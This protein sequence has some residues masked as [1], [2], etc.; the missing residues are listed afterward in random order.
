M[1][2]MMADLPA[3]RVETFVKPFTNVAVDYTGA[4]NY[5]L[6][7]GRGYK[8]SK[9]YIAIFVCMSI[10]AIYIELV[11]DLT[12]EACIAA[13]RRVIARRGSIENVYS[14]NGTNFVR[15]NKD[16]FQLCDAGFLNEF[17]DELSKM[18]TTWNLSPAGAPHFNGLAEA[19][20]KS[21]KTFLKK[22]MGNLT[23]TFEELSTLLCQIEASSALSVV[24]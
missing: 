11:S 16:L 19:A 13:F 1:N 5:K 21:V 15:A 3:A 2:Q 6:A 18:G 10:K 22:S 17:S 12:A 9:A 23:L 24:I 14:D 20:V 8:T 7:K 4:I